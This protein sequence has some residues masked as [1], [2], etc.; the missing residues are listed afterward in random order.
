[1][2]GQKRPLEDTLHFT[3]TEEQ[4]QEKEKITILFISSRTT[5]AIPF[6]LI[7]IRF[8]VVLC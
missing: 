6:R 2:R 4:E 5:A 8:I 3:W 7:R 1:M